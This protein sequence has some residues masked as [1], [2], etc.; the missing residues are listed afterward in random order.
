MFTVFTLYEVVYLQFLLAYTES[1]KIRKSCL[2]ANDR[3]SALK[4][5]VNHSRLKSQRAGI[6]CAIFALEFL[7]DLSD[8]FSL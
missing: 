5:K 2:K 3:A 6:V 8:V 4:I 1:P 7:L